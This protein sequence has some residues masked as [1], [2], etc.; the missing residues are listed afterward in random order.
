RPGPAR[1]AQTADGTAPFGAVLKA[2]N[3]CD[4]PRDP[5]L[6]HRRGA[7]PAGAIKKAVVD[8][9]R[10]DASLAAAVLPALRSQPS[11]GQVAAALRAL[12]P[13]E[14][15]VPNRDA[16]DRF[17]NSR[18]F[19]APDDSMLEWPGWMREHA[20][21]VPCRPVDLVRL[22][23]IVADAIDPTVAEPPAVRR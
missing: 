1:T 3:V 12:A 11:A 17:L 22:S 14:K 9:A 18:D 2:A 13:D 5:G 4:E 10:G 6:I 21:P 20:R 23:T 15:G 7:D 19:P 8:A 16:I